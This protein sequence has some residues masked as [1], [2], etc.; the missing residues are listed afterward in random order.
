MPRVEPCVGLAMC[1]AVLSLS[2]T[3]G[4]SAYGV[5]TFA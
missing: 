4:N 1:T 5:Y 2:A 3:C